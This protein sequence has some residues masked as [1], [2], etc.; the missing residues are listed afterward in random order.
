M[1]GTLN[2]AAYR[3]GNGVVLVQGAIEQAVAPDA[4]IACFSNNLV[5]SLLE[6]LRSPAVNS[7]VMPL[8]QDSTYEAYLH[9]CSI[10]IHFGKY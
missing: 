5:T 1:A 2:R 3:A 9:C 4:S 7:S 8:G 10:G 6:W